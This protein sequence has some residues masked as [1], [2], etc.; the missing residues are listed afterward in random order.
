MIKNSMLYPLRFYPIY[1]QAIWG[2][3]RFWSFLGRELL[4]E[5]W[6]AESW[7]ISGHPDGIS[8]V[9]NG[10]LRGKT[11]ESL[12]QEYPEELLGIH[13][14]SSRFPLLVKFLDANQQLSVQVHPNQEYVAQ[15]GFSDQAKAEAW[16]V[17]HAEPG[18]R[19]TLGF[20]HP[21]T[22][23]EVAE[24]L[25]KE[26]LETLLFSVEPQEGECYF[27][28]PGTVH[29]LGA[30][31]LLYEVQQCSN[32]TLRLYD[33]N[34]VDVHGRKRTLHT[35][36]G[37]AAMNPHCW[38]AQKVVPRQISL[39]KETLLESEFFCL[40]RWRLQNQE[41]CLEKKGR[42]HLLTVLSGEVFVQGLA[43]P[44][45]KGETVLIPAQCSGIALRTESPTQILDAY[46]P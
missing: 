13:A 14:A 15:Q 39:E 18:S 9:A 36:H 16:V 37:L 19:M 44:L 27:L 1:K 45:G 28:P 31:I 23:E 42:C 40:D 32:L 17:L 25:E 43:E 22:R 38:N 12:R 35:E 21:V 10:S 46:M 29:S 2:G 4:E 11:L 33:W 24:A 26:C 41:T 3:R 8:V 34:R 20:Q 7:E 5:E 6:V 30:G